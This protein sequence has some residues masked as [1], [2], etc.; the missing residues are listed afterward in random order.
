M[1]VCFLVKL[2][3]FLYFYHLIF[4]S[5]FSPVKGVSILFLFAFEV[6]TYFQIDLLELF[7]NMYS[8]YCSMQTAL[9]HSSLLLRMTLPPI[10]TEVQ[11]TNKS[12]VYLRCTTW[13]F[14]I[15]LY[16]EMFT[17]VKLVN[18]SI[19]SHSYYVCGKSI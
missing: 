5:I 11:I 18:I 2:D 17:T 12:C 15:H 10:I 13:C 14:D 16:C 9:P 6:L 3:I 7:L 19:T 4:F 1:C 8:R